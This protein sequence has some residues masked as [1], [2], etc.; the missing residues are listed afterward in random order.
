M[1]SLLALGFLHYLLATAFVGTCLLLIVIILLQKGRGGGIGSAFG[2]GG[3]QSAF[4]AKT[5][6]IF[7][8]ITVALAGLYLLFAV[9]SNFVFVPL[10]V[11]NTTPPQ[12]QSTSQEPPVPPASG[13]NVPAKN[14]PAKTGPGAA[15]VP[16][17]SPTPVTNAPVTTPQNT[18]PS[19][20]PATPPA[21]TSPPVPKP[22]TQPAH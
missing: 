16:P 4:G 10:G 9:I 13:T 11:A 17:A 20:K 18:K 1:N 12:L 5:G 19:A 7:T 15:A 8:W 21:V 14:I 22:A 3:G 2:G 6:D